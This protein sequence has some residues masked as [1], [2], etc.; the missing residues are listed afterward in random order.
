MESNNR[1]RKGNSYPTVDQFHSILKKISPES[2]FTKGSVEGLREIYLAYMQQVASSL[3]QW[4]TLKEEE[5]IIEALAV[6]PTFNEYVQK[7]KAQLKSA[8]SSQKPPPK[9]KRRKKK[10]TEKDAA[11]QERLLLQSKQTMQKAASK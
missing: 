6:N 3:T 9:K 2:T 10:L 1:K 11:E 5:K 7:A 8:A 4:D